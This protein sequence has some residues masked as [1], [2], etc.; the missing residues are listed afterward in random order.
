MDKWKRCVDHTINIEKNYLEKDR[1]ADQNYDNMYRP[2]II[3]LEETTSES[4]SD[5]ESEN[6]SD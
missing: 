1:I 5:L 2:F 6:D 4:S 3:E